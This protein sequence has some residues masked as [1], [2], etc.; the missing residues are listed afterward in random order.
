MLNH[1]RLWTA[2]MDRI[3]LMVCFSAQSETIFGLFSIF[4]H[5]CLRV[6]YI[7]QN[8]PVYF[9]TYCLT[10]YCMCLWV[11]VCVTTT[12]WGAEGLPF[13]HLGSGIELSSSGLVTST[14]TLAQNSPVQVYILLNTPSPK[15]N[16]DMNQFLKQSI[17]V[18]V[19][20]SS[21]PGSGM[22]S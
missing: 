3:W 18:P 15:S 7:K 20:L 2:L 8:L 13:H 17:L 21:F 19:Y 5:L 6:C 4:P 12:V 22:P 14:I 9:L 10:I 16:L 11:W 1:W